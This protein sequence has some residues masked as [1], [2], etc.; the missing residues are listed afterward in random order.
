MQL[1]KK[2]IVFISTLLFFSIFS[3]SIFSQ[4]KKIRDA[5]LDVPQTTDLLDRLNKMGLSVSGSVIST[6]ECVLELDKLF[7]RFYRGDDAR[8]QKSGGYGI[9]LSVAKTIVDAL[10]GTITVQKQNEN[11]IIFVITLPLE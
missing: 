10:K 1:N 4:T 2:R 11:K 5:G 6:E 9:G 8:T 3:L 7:D